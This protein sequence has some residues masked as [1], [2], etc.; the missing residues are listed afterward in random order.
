MDGGGS[1]SGSRSFPED[2]F[3]KKCFLFFVR[4]KEAGVGKKQESGPTRFLNITLGCDID[5]K[6]ALLAPPSILKVGTF[7]SN[8]TQPLTF[9][10]FNGNHQTFLIAKKNCARIENKISY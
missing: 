3:E 6:T 2:I 4:R 8:I 10:L 1:S 5:L 9:I 7:L